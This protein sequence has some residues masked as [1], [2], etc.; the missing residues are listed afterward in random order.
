MLLKLLLLRTML[1]I[2]R[3]SSCHARIRIRSHGRRDVLLRRLMRL[4]STKVIMRLLLLLLLLRLRLR[5]RLLL[6]LNTIVRMLL[7]RR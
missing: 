1:I 5:L 3:Q 4:L 7:L 2:Q 6:S